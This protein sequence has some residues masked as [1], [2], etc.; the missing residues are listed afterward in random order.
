MDMLNPKY[1]DYNYLND[2]FEYF[3]NIIFNPNMK[4][5]EFD[6]S[7]LNTI[8]TRLIADIKTTKES[9]TKYSV[10]QALTAMDKTSVS[11][12]NISG[13]DADLYADTGRI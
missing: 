10:Q 12:I 9:P 11:S 8:K 4:D 13:T 1:A 3:F 7:T 6:E 2:A 5:E